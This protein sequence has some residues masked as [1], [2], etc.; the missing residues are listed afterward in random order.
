MYSFQFS[1]LSVDN[2]QLISSAAVQ[3]EPAEVCYIVGANGSG[4]SS[5][6]QTLAGNPAYQLQD[7]SIIM[8]GKEYNDL[9]AA[10]RAK[11]GM[12]FISQYVPTIPGLTVSRFLHETAGVLGLPVLSF[13][14]FMVDA[15]RALEA[16]GLTASF[17]S[18]D[19]GVGFSGGERKRFELA[20]VLL[21]KPSVILLDELDSGLDKH[22]LAIMGE[23]L[24]TYR[25]ENPQTI[26]ILVTHYKNLLPYLPATKAYSLADGA[27]QPLAVDELPQ[28]LAGGMH[29]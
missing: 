14:S 4:K 13:D 16:V 27:L 12:F 22:A 26:M 6:L 3:L 23:R 15:Q 20:Q 7:G 2:K 29:G 19:V 5:L 18:R 21:F 24:R 25:Q 28:Y 9:D 11:D 8:H 17:L 1:S 10:K